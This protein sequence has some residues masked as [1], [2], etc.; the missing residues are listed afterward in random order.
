VYGRSV[1][2]SSGAFN[3]QLTLTS[4]GGLADAAVSPAGKLAVIWEQSSIP[5]PVQARFGP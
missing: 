1:T 3:G 4:D 5:W 2:V